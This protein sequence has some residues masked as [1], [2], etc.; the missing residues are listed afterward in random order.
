MRML[1]VCIGEHVYGVMSVLISRLRRVT[2]RNPNP[3]TTH[4]TRHTNLLVLL[5]LLLSLWP[6]MQPRPIGRVSEYPLASV[7][8]PHHRDLGTVGSL[9]P[10]QTQLTVRSSL[11]RWVRGGYC[12]CACV[13]VSLFFACV[14]RIV[15]VCMCVHAHIHVYGRQDECNFSAS[16]MNET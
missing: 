5:L 4:T 13:G 15:C 7:Q 9:G 6:V 3:E 14:C 10:P 12:I 8:D 2:P 16:A 1:C 11:G